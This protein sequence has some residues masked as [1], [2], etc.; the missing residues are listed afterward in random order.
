MM[1]Y[2][3]GFFGFVF[4]FVVGGG[5]GGGGWGAGGRCGVVAT[6]RLLHFF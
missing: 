4:V 1:L 5:G 2:G 3:C 6:R